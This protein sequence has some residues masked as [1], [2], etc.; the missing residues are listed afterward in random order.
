MKKKQSRITNK[1]DTI[2]FFMSN[3]QRHSRNN[4]DDKPET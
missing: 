2:E 3:K 1:T 4:R